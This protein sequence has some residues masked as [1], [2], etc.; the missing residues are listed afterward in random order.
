MRT[1]LTLDDTLLEQALAL[2]PPGMDKA[3]LIRESVKAYIQLQ[4]AR[5]LA[6]LGG[7]M[8]EVQ[9]APRRRYTAAEQ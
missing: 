9:E 2:S 8:P 1:T 7:C 3:A 6:D 5:R 4:A